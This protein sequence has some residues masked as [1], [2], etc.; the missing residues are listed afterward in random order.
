MKDNWWKRQIK[1]IT[2]LHWHFLYG[3]LFL[4]ELAVIFHSN[5]DWKYYVPGS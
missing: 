1:N 3:V 2:A 5:M 4:W